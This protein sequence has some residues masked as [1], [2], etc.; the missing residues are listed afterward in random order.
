MEKYADHIIAVSVDNANRIKLKDKTSVVYQHSD[1]SND[2]PNDDS[3]LSKTVLYV[4]GAAYI[5]GYFTLV[6]ALEYIDDDI[7]I[8]FAGY[9][10]VNRI[11][12]N[13]YFVR[14]IKLLFSRTYRKNTIAVRKMRNSHNAIEVG[15]IPNITFYL[16]KVCCLVSPFAVT[17]FSRPVIEA[18]ANYKPAI[19]SDVEGMSE[20]VE[21]NV[22]GIIVKRS[23]AKEL[24]NAINYLCNNPNI[25]K[26]M[27]KQ[28]YAKALRNYSSDNIRVIGNIYKSLLDRTKV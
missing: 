5:K 4:G 13:R 17:H 20:I 10:P 24:A 7:R 18:F 28:G 8:L 23:N 14:Q 16:N 3:Y 25:A 12:K 2:K 27:G 19:V 26:N 6:E 11:D 21:N 22:D 9:Y 15:L 1:L